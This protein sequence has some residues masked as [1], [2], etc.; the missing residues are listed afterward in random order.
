[1]IKPTIANSKLFIEKQLMKAD[2]QVVFDYNKK[3]RGAYDLSLVSY[4]IAPTKLGT[5]K[6]A[7]I[8]DYLKFFVNTCSQQN[9]AQQGYVALSGT[10]LR[11]ANELIGRIK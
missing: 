9:A 6:A 7:A 10:L 4:G 3:I 1:M 8:A 2:G 5:P 11:K